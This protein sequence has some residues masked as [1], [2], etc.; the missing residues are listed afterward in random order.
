MKTKNKWLYL[1][2]ETKNRELYSRVLL[3]HEALQRNYNVVLG[4]KGRIMQL[5]RSTP[6]GAVLFKDH[7]TELTLNNMKLA[8][9]AGH[10]ILVL[11]E[12]MV[13]THPDKIFSKVRV[14]PECLKL[15]DSIFFL[16]S[17][18]KSLYDRLKITKNLNSWAI[19]GNPR[20]DLLMPQVRPIY[21]DEAQN[22][23]DRFGPFI[24]INTNFAQG[25]HADGSRGFLYRLS[26]NGFMGWA[27][28]NCIGLVF[29]A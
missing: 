5:I 22:L 25:N 24:L 7:A 28:L 18:H 26:K 12:E 16:G 21:S 17:D 14:N 10:K 27:S 15:I 3:A 13:V 2:I 11:D 20:F 1:Q 23:K 4:S 6:Q 8:K 19:T 9:S 29:V